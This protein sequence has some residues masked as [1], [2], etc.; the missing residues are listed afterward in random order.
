M[1][2]EK[3]IGLKEM[4]LK[5][6]DELFAPHDDGEPLFVVGP[7]ELEIAFTVERDLQGGINFHVIEYGAEKKW[8]EAQTIKLTLNPVL[9]TADVVV[10]LTDEQKQKAKQA[11]K[12]EALDLD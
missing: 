7:V 2:K 3:P 11:L 10:D 4:I 8:T 6:K 9:S 5:V 1:S 12:R